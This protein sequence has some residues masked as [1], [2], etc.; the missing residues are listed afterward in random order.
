MR[1]RVYREHKS[2]KEKL[3]DSRRRNELSPER[4]RFARDITRC[5]AAVSA[6]FAQ[7]N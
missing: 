5:K 2:N 4:D 1:I 3:V 7:Q 6:A